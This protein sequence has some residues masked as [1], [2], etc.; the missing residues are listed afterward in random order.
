MEYG[1]KVKEAAKK[2]LNTRESGV[3]GRV[4]CLVIAA[5][6]EPYGS[7]CF[8]LPVAV[9]LMCSSFPG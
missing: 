9:E 5:L 2:A 7:E 1:Y 3:K 6:P 4:S 8:S